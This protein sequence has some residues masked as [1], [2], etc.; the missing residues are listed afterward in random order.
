M[1]R[2]LAISGLGLAIALAVPTLARATDEKTLASSIC[3]GTFPSD[4]DRTY[5]YT[6][7]LRAVGGE[8]QLNC[9]LIRDTIGKRMLW[10]DV[11][12][13]KTTTNKQISGRVYSCNAAFHECQWA[14]ANSA[15]SSGQHSVFIDTS[16]LPYS[17]TYGR[18]FSYWTRLPEGD[19]LMSLNS[20][21]DD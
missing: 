20:K 13:D 7:E 4:R 18:Y 12:Y 6:S 9:S 11:R 10:V 5:Y 15:A 2:T 14:A 8:A 19:W 16:S 17:D 21:E 1:T 3:Q